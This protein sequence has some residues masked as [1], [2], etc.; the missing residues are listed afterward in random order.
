MSK[1]DTATQEL[2]DNVKSGDP[3]DKL[4]TK[5]LRER[6]SYLTGEDF[7]KESERA[8]K[9]V[10]RAHE[11][12]VSAEAERDE[13]KKKRTR[14]PGAKQTP[15]QSFLSRADADGAQAAR[16]AATI[17]D[18]KGYAADKK[19]PKMDKTM[20]RQTLRVLAL[21]Y[22]ADALSDEYRE[23]LESQFGDK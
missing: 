10:I 15:M 1:Q 22:K 6:A 8:C 13:A 17:A 14:G 11:R 7:S 4:T 23:F 18:P 20:K 19:A 12:A 16:C 3:L 5:E 21:L 2:R 9:A